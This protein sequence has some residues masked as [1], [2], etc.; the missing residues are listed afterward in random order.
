LSFLFW[1]SEKGNISYILAWSFS[2]EIMRQT[3]GFED[4][5]GRSIILAPNILIFL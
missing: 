1:Y 4:V 5:G 3:H 2:E